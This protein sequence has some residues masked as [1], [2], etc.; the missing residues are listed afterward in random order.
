MGRWWAQAPLTAL[1]ADVR[2]HEQPMP[3]C[4]DVTGSLLL[5]LGRPGLCDHLHTFRLSNTLP[6][7]SRS[8][9]SAILMLL[10]HRAPELAF[11]SLDSMQA[12]DAPTLTASLCLLGQLRHLRHLYIKPSFRDVSCLGLLPHLRTLHVGYSLDV[13]CILRPSCPLPALR[14]LICEDGCDANWR[15][16]PSLSYLDTFFRVDDEPLTLAPFASSLRTLLLWITP[17]LIVVP[18]DLP[19]LEALLCTPET[20]MALPSLPAVTSLELA[21][22]DMPSPLPLPDNVVDK[23][24][25]LPGLVDLNVSLPEEFSPTIDHVNHIASLQRRLSRCSVSLVPFADIGQP[26]P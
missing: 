3:C 18:A 22:Y 20:F 4:N 8:Q 1:F 16:L 7:L 10:A 9:Y 21:A 5:L 17:P 12:M 24:A 25:S 11:L 15:H 13:P 6:Q 26:F 14:T 19:H 2:K 23:A